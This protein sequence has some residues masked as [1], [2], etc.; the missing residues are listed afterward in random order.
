MENGHWLELRKL[1]LDVMVLCKQQRC[2]QKKIVLKRPVQRLHRLEIASATSQVIPEDAPVHGGEKLISNCVDSKN[3]SVTKSKRNVALSKGGQ[4]GENVAL[5][6]GGQGGENVKAHYTCSG[7]LS[8]KL[9]RLD[10]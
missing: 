4:G 8:K 7:R 10:L 9:N 6:K 3:V 1:T 2:K 5:P